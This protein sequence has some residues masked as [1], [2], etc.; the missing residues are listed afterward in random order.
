MAGKGRGDLTV[1]P[2]IAPVI[3]PLAVVASPL[4]RCPRSLVEAKSE[5]SEND[6]VINSRRGFLRKPVKE[7]NAAMSFAPHALVREKT[8]AR[9]ARFEYA[10]N[11]ANRNVEIG[12][13]LKNLIVNDEIERC[14]R[15]RS[16]VAFHSKYERPNVLRNVGQ[17]GAATIKDV[18]ADR[19]QASLTHQ[20]NYRTCP[21]AIVENFEV[22]SIGAVRSRELS[23]KLIV[24]H[25]S[26]NH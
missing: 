14:I 10:G 18:A 8:Q 12:D 20:A 1:R 25:L 9:A 5:Q 17:V 21:T 11:L 15:E 13:V 26:L 7:R 23:T 4:D 6:G 22:G 19:L 2:V 24:V 3:Q 16:S